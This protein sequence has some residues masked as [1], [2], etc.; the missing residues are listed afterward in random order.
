MSKGT[1]IQFP[2][3]PQFSGDDIIRLT[4]ELQMGT[5]G[6]KFSD[7]EIDFVATWGGDDVSGTFYDTRI[8]SAYDLE[9]DGEPGQYTWPELAILLREQKAR[10]S[11]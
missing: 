4:Q 6:S 2:Q 11:R 1:L 7:A 9:S 10:N 8:T 5:P 3:S